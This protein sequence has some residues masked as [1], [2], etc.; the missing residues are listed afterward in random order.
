MRVRNVLLPAMTVLLIS[1]SSIDSRPQKEGYQL[2][3]RIHLYDKAKWSFAGRL[4]LAD[5]NKSFSLSIDWNHRLEEDEIE[6]AGPFGLGRTVITMDEGEVGIATDG[7]QMRLKGS[8]EDI[9]AEYTGMSLPVESLKYWVLGL[10]NPDAE[11]VLTED[12]F[13]QLG[14]QIYYQ[15]MQMV[16]DDRLPRKMKVEKADKRLKM[17]VDDWDV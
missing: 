10:V 15:E 14:W 12:G 8:A 3:E 1:C 16:G 2:T 5:K 4:A 11:Y 6:L 9:I 7:Q 17:V 13:L